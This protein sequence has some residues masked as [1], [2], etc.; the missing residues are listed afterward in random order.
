[1]ATRPAVP[2]LAVP[3]IA[4]LLLNLVFSSAG[5]P[6]EGMLR[7]RRPVALVLADE[8]RWLFVANQRSGTVSVIDTAELRPVA[9][10]EVGRR[11]AD[12][13]LVAGGSRLLA[14]DEEAG[15]LVILGRKGSALEPTRRIKVGPAPVSV[16]T[17][18]DGSRCFV[19]LLWS[20]QLACLDLTA[21]E[22]HVQVVS[23]P[24]APRRQLLVREGKKL[25]VADSFGGRFAVVDARRGE[26]EAVRELPAHN[27][28]GLALAADADHLLV[29][30]QMLSSRASST[31]DDIHWG[32]LITNNVRTLA[33]AAVLATK[34]DPLEHGHLDYL[35]EVNRGAGDPAGI[36]LA[37]DGKII[38]TLAGV[39]EVAIGPGADSGWQRLPVGRRPTAV[40]VSPDGRRAYVANTFGDSIS[41]MDLKGRKVETEVSL[42]AAPEPDPA[43]RGE[44]LFH[45]ARLAHDG[46]FSC[47][48]CHPDGHT[49]G[50]LNDNLTDG[51]LGTPKRILSLLGARDTAPYAWNG[52]MADLE[53]Q[54]RQSVQSTMQGAKPT[55]EQV[56]DL[57]AFV[58]TL[59][60]PPSL[61]RLRG[62]VDEPGVRRGQAVFQREGCA[63]CHAPPA[64]TSAKAFN[65]GLRDEAGNTAFNP[66]SLRGV[67]QGGPYFHNN[68]AATLEEVFTRHRHQ[69]KSELPK[70]DLDDLLLFLRVL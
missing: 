35:G 7:L 16:Q 29:T 68:G 14:V 3:G 18:P 63:S 45:D 62:E 31:F 33:L 22:P 64:Y 61:A 23:L 28:R 41:V 40:A 15:E 42:G 50:L 60:P 21:K 24:F 47:S 54:V 36:A 70:Q 66:P 39:G 44:V 34:G 20:R 57:V 53:S 48:S 5:S 6:A 11:L 25:I 1:M 8:G 59:P 65:V 46:W 37:P 58:Q 49:T 4:G 56:R 26:V 9:E 43:Q 52:K 27:I 10:V 69:L 30:H 51:S 12:L 13:A 17:S 19:A 55:G 2:L 38:I 67:S 32:N